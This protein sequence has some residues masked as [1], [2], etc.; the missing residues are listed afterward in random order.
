[1][2]DHDH[3]YK[4]LFSHPEMV[5]DLL[6]GFV[7]EEWVSNLDF[8][9]LEKV[10]G[11]YVS[12]DL[13]ERE[14]D[15]IWRVRFGD[16]WLYVYLLLEFQSTVDRFMALRIMTYTGLLYQDLV[17]TKQL[18]ERGLLPPV[19]PI[20]LYNGEQRWHAPVEIQDLVEESPGGLGRYRPRLRYLLL[21]EGALSAEEMGK[22][23]NLVSALFSLEQSFSEKNVL[24]VVRNLLEW[25]DE[26]EQS[27]LR[28]AFTVWFNRMVVPGGSTEPSFSELSEVKTML[29]ERWKEWNRKWMEQGIEQGIEQGRR[30]GQAELLLR[31]LELKFG[32]LSER[33]R[34]E[35]EDGTDEQLICWSERILTVSAIEDIFTDSPT[36]DS[37]TD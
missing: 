25:L 3:S 10:S 23:R 34:H 22:A 35:V 24:R 2:G 33:V 6:V 19:L 27:G 11:T 17:R 36:D 8:D 26:P 12:D 16:R 37:P 29:S 14:D 31:Q 20:V 28:R 4:L 30:R 1:M 9:T 13:R 18:T 5:R 21:D 32:A 7:R 15:L